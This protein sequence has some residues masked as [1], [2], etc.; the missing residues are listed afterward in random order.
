MAID[1][2][3][4]KEFQKAITTAL[5]CQSYYKRSNEPDMLAYSQSILATLYYNTGDYPTSVE[6]AQAS[7]AIRK[8]LG[9]EHDIAESLNNLALPYMALKQW[10]KAVVSLQEALELMQRSNDIRQ[11]PI[12]KQNLASCIWRK[13]DASEAERLLMEVVD[14]ATKSGQK[15]AIANAYKKLS[16]LFKEKED[17]ATALKYYQKYK[18]WSDSLYSYEK[19]QAISELNIKYETNK[20]EAQIARLNDEKRLNSVMQIVFV[21]LLLSTII[22]ATLTTLYLTSRNRK[23]KLMLE[24]V[25][26]ELEMNKKDLTHFTE[27]VITKN[28]LIGEL[29]TKLQ[30]I[31]TERAAIEENNE[32]LS[33]LYRFKILTEDD[34]RQFKIYFDKVYP[35]LI[36]A[37]RE[38]YPD[39]TPAEER[40][41]LL[42]TLNINNKESADMLGISLASIKKNRY[43]LK[44]RFDLTEQDD[45]DA[46]VKNFHG[47][48]GNHNTGT[49]ANG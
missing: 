32:S 14:E 25:S 4:Q 17:F 15:D 43:R 48:S 28:K 47:T 11:I 6:Y 33:E 8:Q 9:I 23:N 18:S 5:A 24:K 34:W 31:S 22:V 42:I 49:D 27:S 26:L 10:D 7:L 3:Y 1:L 29:E 13:G 16:N 37:L 45:L 41:F 36:H 2:Y 19:E 21:I 35:G 12:I 44:K 30:T 20:K 46:F 40:Q 39:L 38:K